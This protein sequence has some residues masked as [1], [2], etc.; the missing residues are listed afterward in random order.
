MIAYF[1]WEYII[2]N[3]VLKVPVISLLLLLSGI[4][5]YLCYERTYAWH[6]S[7]TLL[8]D[9]IEKYPYRALLSY[10]WLGNYYLDKGDLD[11]ALEN[12]KVLD[13]LHAADAKVLD[14][15]G[16]IYTLKKDFTHAIGAFNNSQGVQGN[17]YKTYLDRCIAYS[18]AGDTLNAFK[19]YIQSFR[20]NPGSER[21]LADSSFVFV[22]T[23]RFDAAINMYSILLKLS[24][25]NPFYYFYRGVAQFSSNKMQ[26]A[27]NDWEIAVK[28]PSKDVQQ[29]ASYNLSVAY[30]SLGN[31][32]K[33]FYYINMAKEKGYAGVTDEFYKKLKDKSTLP[34]ATHK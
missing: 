22:Q 12:Y 28:M 8:T 1:V 20:L 27:I 13:T 16:K 34:N 2:H 18:M 25:S 30:D 24:T 23:K 17:V 7:E 21:I 10:K 32:S 33:A 15:I 19:D 26:N 5:S 29:S 11:K 31:H 9:A 3:P 4:L 6:D 14:N